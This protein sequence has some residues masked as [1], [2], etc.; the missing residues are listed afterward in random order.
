MRA[1]RAATY[2]CG[3]TSPAGWHG[4]CKRRYLFA[5]P[6]S[7]DGSRGRR[8]ERGRA[9]DGLAVDAIGFVTHVAMKSRFRIERAPRARWSRS[10]GRVFT[11]RLL[12]RHPQAESGGWV[13]RAT[14][15]RERENGHKVGIRGQAQ[16][17]QAQLS[18]AAGE[19]YVEPGPLSPPYLHSLSPLAEKWALARDTYVFLRIDRPPPVPQRRVPGLSLGACVCSPLRRRK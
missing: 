1:E 12:H 16:L 5:G 15:R 9:T 3:W 14:R 18:Q 4:A 17:S 19:N 10:A 7:A 13:G 11:Q 8:Q 2:P 6:S